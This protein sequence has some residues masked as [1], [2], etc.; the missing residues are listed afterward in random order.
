M[1]KWQNYEAYRY[2]ELLKRDVVKAVVRA[3]DEKAARGFL[4]IVLKKIYRD[5]KPFK[6]R[7]QEV[8][9]L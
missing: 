5:K 6:V 4:V 9:K 2:S 3:P 1:E 7:R 8:T